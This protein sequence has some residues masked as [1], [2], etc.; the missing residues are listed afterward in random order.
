MPRKENLSPTGSYALA[1]N[2]ADVHTTGFETDIQC[3]KTFSKEQSIWATLGLT[4]LDTKSSEPTTS[5]YISSHAKFLTNLSVNYLLKNWTLNATAIYKERN[6]MTANAINVKVDE[7]CFMLN[8]KADYSIIRSRFF[9]F[10][11]ADNLLNNSCR[12]M[13]GSLKPA[14]WLM[15]GVKLSIDK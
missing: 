1:T 2:V 12:D 6:P 8:M 5:F 3:A 13:L 9:C 15:G 14:R 11:E 7:R 4:W 10:V